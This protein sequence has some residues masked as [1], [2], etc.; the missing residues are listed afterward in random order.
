MEIM[1]NGIPNTLSLSNK[2][3]ESGLPGAWAAPSEPENKAKCLQDQGAAL[4][5]LQS[6]MPETAD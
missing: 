5:A 4:A 6:R 1:D 3:L 2:Y